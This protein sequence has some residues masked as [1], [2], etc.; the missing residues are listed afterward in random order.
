TNWAYGKIQGVISTLSQER[1]GFLIAFLALY[2]TFTSKSMWTVACFI[3]HR[4]LYSTSRQDGLYDQRQAI[5]RNAESAHN[6]VLSLLHAGL[7]W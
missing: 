1:G 4:R 5:L 6:A 3:I 7:S 2:V